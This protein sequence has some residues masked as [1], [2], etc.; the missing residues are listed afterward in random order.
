LQWAEDKPNVLVSAAEDGKLIVWNTITTNKLKVISA[1]SLWVTS[2]AISPSGNIVASGGLDNVCAVFNLRGEIPIRVSRE[3]NGHSG[4]ISCI[5]F[6][7]EKSVLTSSGDKTCVLWD[8]ETG[9]RI[10]R[11]IEH[12]KDVMSISIHPTDKN[13]FVSGGLDGLAKVWDVRTEKSVQQFEEIRDINAIQFF[14]NGHCFGT[15]SEDS[16]CRLY[17]LRADRELM[18]YQVNASSTSSLGSSADL[19]PS[20]TLTSTGSSTNLNESSSPNPATSLAF[21]LSGKYLFAGYDDRNCYIWDVLRG[22]RI[23]SLSGHNGRVSCVGVSSD[24]MAVCTG[25]WDSELKVWA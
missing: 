3:L 12:T 2:C 20:T 21:S 15:A 1:Q 18:I 24:G 16:C 4:F 9:S 23:G 19:N 17:D 7:S 5:R 25:G 6:A 11:F 8:A 14:P 22:E 13:V 10:K